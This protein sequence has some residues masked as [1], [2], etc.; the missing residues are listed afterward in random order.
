[1][2]I[3]HIGK[4]D[5]A[6][7][8]KQVLFVFIIIVFFI[9][10]FALYILLSKVTINIFPKIEKKEIKEEVS[11]INNLKENDYNDNFLN[12][13]FLEETSRKTKKIDDLAP[14]KIEE[15]AVGEVEIFNGYERAQRFNKGEILI[16]KGEDPQ[17]IVINED[18][19][20][21]R[22][23]TKT[24]QA[25]A[26]AKGIIGQIP[27]GELYFE[28]YD[29]AMNQKITAKNEEPF[30][31]G[32]RSASLVTEVDVEVA[33]NDLR[34]ELIKDNLKKLKE[35]VGEEEFLDQENSYNEILE[36]KAS[37]DPPFETNNFEITMQ[38]KT[39]AVVFAKDEILELA[40]QKLETRAGQENEFLTLD[41]LEEIELEIT[42]FNEVEKRAVILIK[43]DGYFK[44]KLPAEVF[45]K[46]E[47]KGY[48]ERALLNYY[49]DFEDIEKVEVEFWP[50]F[51]KTV[52]EIDEQIVFK[53]AEIDKEKVSQD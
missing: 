26:L 39:T 14:K 23:Q 12:G 32:V 27:P 53:V 20:L 51:R 2:S 7:F 24:I 1:M 25:Y 17:K 48:N 10:L 40:N 50:Y 6:K 42:D 33:K 41:K 36:F 31:G 38:L 11:I 19:I 5:S 28:K 46:G 52:P 29:Q 43:F 8:Y 44:P 22:N 13:I 49:K 37:V 35:K 15:N 16:T 4:Y 47:I 9:S 45:D 18:F 21:Y 3:E 30:V 34:K